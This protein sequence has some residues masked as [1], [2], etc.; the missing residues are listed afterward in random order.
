[1]NALTPQ[2]TLEIDPR[3]LRILRCPASGL[4]L[5][6]NEGQLV[7]SD[8]KHRYDVV[9]GVPCLI[10][11]RAE[12]THA[13]YASI[14]AQNRDL[15][16]LDVDTYLTNMVASTC[17]N[18]FHGVKFSGDYPLPEFPSE[19]PPGLTL[20][21]GCNWGC[22]SIAGARVG[23]TMIG[24]DIHLESL[25]VAR[26]LS[27]RLA[28]GNQPLF[29]VAD[30]RLLPFAPETF[31]AV[32]SYSVVQ[33]F[34]RENAVTVLREAGRVMRSGAVSMVQMPNW[35]GIRPSL[36]RWSKR[37]AKASE[38]DVRYYA[39]NDLMAIFGSAIGTTDWRVDCFLG[40]NV[41]KWD[42]AFV[43]WTRRWIIDLA[44]AL[45][46]LSRLVPPLGRLSDSVYL[47]SIKT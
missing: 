4:P 43:P 1:M 21:I 15:P 12:P 10:H 27:H 5:S 25:L 3:L 24:L 22:W 46:R 36:K 19:L 39:L 18:L 33:H 45:N 37:D 14:I 47:R 31:G 29:V 30:A 13:G 6:A 34:S 2:A 23:Y 41:H 42:R 20:E 35:A 26:K 17:G 32:F 11:P 7:S 16:R 38:F 44:E 40:L 28:P 9:D 8:G